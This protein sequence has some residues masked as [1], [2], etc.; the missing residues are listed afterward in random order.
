[1]HCPWPRLQAGGGGSGAVAFT[2]M[3]KLA[4]KPNLYNE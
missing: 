4:I 1:M 3:H 2:V